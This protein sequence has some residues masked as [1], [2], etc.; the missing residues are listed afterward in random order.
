MQALS[1]PV[2][3][4]HVLSA[5]DTD[6]AA[7]SADFCVAIDSGNNAHA[8]MPNLARE[9]SSFEKP[10]SIPSVGSGTPAAFASAE[11]ETETDGDGQRSTSAWTRS[12]RSVGQ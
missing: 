8:S 2:L 11:T 4:P 1:D 7:S 12:G 5:A 3:R 9:T 10:A 6:A